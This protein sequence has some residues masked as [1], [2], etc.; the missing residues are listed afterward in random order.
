MNRTPFKSP[1][2]LAPLTAAAALSMSSMPALAQT[3]AADCSAINFDLANPTPAS[4][5][6]PGKYVVSG[7]AMDRRA[8]Q[9]LGIDRVDFF[10][11]NRDQGGIFLGSAVPG[12]AGFGSFQATISFPRSISGHTFYGYARSNVNGA[13]VSIAIPIAVGEDPSKASLTGAETA[14]LTC[15]A[16]SAGAISPTPG[17]APTTP[18][19]STPAAPTAPGMTAN[20]ST[21]VVS[22]GNPSPGD[23]I[24]VGKFSVQGDAFD[25]AASSGSGVD[26][27]DIF[28]D[29]RDSGGILLA[30]ASLGPGSFWQAIV[31]LPSNQTGLHELWFYAHSSVSGATASASVPVTIQK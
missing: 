18:P 6:E 5:V 9:G 1:R 3:A 11:E 15:H 30:H 17:V 28:L 2:F 10:L 4:R 27:V 20:A 23:T 13:E 26:Q 24:K 14:T 7:V 21:L 8:S 29:S 31:T 22:I 19:P 25:R 12:A 16:G